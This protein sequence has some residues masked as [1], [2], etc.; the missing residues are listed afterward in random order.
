MNALATPPRPTS[1]PFWRAYGHNQAGNR[2]EVRALH[3]HTPR[4]VEIGIQVGAQQPVFFDLHGLGQ[5]L[6]NLRQV[7]IAAWEVD[8]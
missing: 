5:L 4:G 8:R 1:N 7:G 3:V 2:V 6:A